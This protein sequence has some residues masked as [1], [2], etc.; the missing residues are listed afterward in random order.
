MADCVGFWFFHEII[1]GDFGSGRSDLFWALAA[2]LAW[3]RIEERQFVM[4]LADPVEVQVRN[5]TEML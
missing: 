4:V 1:P 5:V 3:V 2:F